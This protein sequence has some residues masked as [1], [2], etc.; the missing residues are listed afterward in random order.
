M[1]AEQEAVFASVGEELDAACRSLAGDNFN[2]LE[3]RF[4]NCDFFHS[5]SL[6]STPPPKKKSF[7]GKK[8]ASSPEI[9]HHPPATRQKKSVL[10]LQLLCGW[11][12]AILRLKL[13]RATPAPRLISLLCLL[14]MRDCFLK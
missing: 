2:K 8:N 9:I 3:V 10:F 7:Q 4:C 12:G 1:E 13:C 11:L 6:L 5:T 14:L